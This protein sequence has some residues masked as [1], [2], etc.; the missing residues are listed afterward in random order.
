ME[1]EGWR[2]GKVKKKGYEN[3]K[4]VGRKGWGKWGEGEK[5]IERKGE[6]VET[7]KRRQE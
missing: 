3:K 6:R 5:E 7:E 2:Q 4:A 1:M